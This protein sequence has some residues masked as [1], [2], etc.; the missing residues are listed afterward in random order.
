MASTKRRVDRFGK[1]LFVLVKVPGTKDEYFIRE[2]EEEATTCRRCGK[3]KRTL[4]SYLDSVAGG[5][6]RRECFMRFRFYDG[7]EGLATKEQ[8]AEFKAYQKRRRAASS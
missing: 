4:Y 3:K 8:V 6:C 2:I 5:F 1:P 7:L